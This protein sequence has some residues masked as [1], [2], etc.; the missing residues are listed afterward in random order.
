MIQWFDCSFSNTNED[1]VKNDKENDG[2]V[3]TIQAKGLDTIEGLQSVLDHAVQEGILIRPTGQEAYMWAHDKL[4]SVAY[5]LIPDNLRPQLHLKLGRLLWK[6]SQK[7]AGQE[8]VVDEDEWMVFMAADQMNRFSELEQQ[9]EHSV[10]TENSRILGAE[11]AT[12][13]LEAARLSLIKSALYPAYD[14]LTAGIKHLSNNNNNNNSAASIDE[15]WTQHYDLCL[16]LYSIMAE[17]SVQLGQDEQ[18]MEAVQQV[19]DHAKCSQDKF[20]VQMVHLKHI[21]S[22]QDRNYELGMEVS[23]EIL[24]EYN[25]RLPNKMLRGVLKIEMNRTRR[26]FP[27][28][29][30]EGILKYPTMTDPKAHNTVKLLNQHAMF[31][32]MTLKKQHRYLGWYASSR[33]LSISA[34]VKAVSE[35][36]AMAIVSLGMAH[37]LQGQFKEANQYGEL[38][39][40]VLE[41]FPQTVGS[42]HATVMTAVASRIFTYTKPLPNC[43]ELFLDAHGIG[44]RTGNT[45]KAGGAILAYAYAYI[46]CGLPLT[47]HSIQSTGN[48]PGRFQDCGTIHFESAGSRTGSNDTYGRRHESRRN[49]LLLPWEC[50][51]YDQT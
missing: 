14:M 48:H 11:L 6:L 31:A 25:V 29:K 51:L 3:G 39:L 33:A 21:T 16:S 40:K 23:E 18:A 19:K 32:T 9:Q 36:T 24:K 10:A 47:G 45:E 20:R 22:G 8:N 15:Q 35:E 17:M 26:R 41:R 30:I 7:T 38:G 5:S 12:L 27:G 37:G 46:T 13:C 2:G 43:L 4:Q 28:G 50:P 44:L 1:A 34:D 49:A 42:I